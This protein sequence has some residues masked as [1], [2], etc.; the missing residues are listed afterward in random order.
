M[1]VV[2]RTLSASGINVAVPASGVVSSI[3]MVPRGRWCMLW[4]SV[5]VL[6]VDET[7]SI[8]SAG[9]LDFVVGV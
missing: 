6:S 7:R 9:V 5:P 3:V 2:S 1:V 8:S 4:P